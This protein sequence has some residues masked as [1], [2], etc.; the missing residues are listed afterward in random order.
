[1]HVHHQHAVGADCAKHLSGDLGRDR[2]AGRTRTTILPGVT[3]VRHD[4][5]H[6]VHRSALERV[7]DDQQFHEML[8][9]RC[10]GRL[11]HEGV[12]AAHVLLDLD[13]HFAVGELADQRFA[14]RH[15][16]LTANRLRQYAIGVTAENEHVLLVHGQVR[17]QLLTV[18]LAG[19]VGF[20][21]TDARIKTWCLGP[22]GDAPSYVVGLPVRLRSRG[23]GQAGTRSSSALS[24]LASAHPCANLQ[25]SI[26]INPCE[27]AP[28]HRTRAS[29][30]PTS[31]PRNADL[32]ATRVAP[33][34]PLRHRRN[35]RNIRLPCR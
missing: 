23:A 22:L 26:R 25:R 34:R 11:D 14:H 3:E 16:E 5:R 1:M 31:P 8:G 19:A 6:R 17:M 15:A 4:R 29:A 7:D 13:L 28:A 35:G 24:C 30:P 27:N 18:E 32:E 10:A 12:L 9:R 20:E 33:L 2:H 21:P